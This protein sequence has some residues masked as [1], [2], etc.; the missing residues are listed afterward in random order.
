MIGM[1]V[2][3]ASAPGKILWIGGY[4]VIERPNVSFVTGVNKRVFAKFETLDSQKAIFIIPQFNAKVEA[5]VEGGQIVFESGLSE[6]ERNA[7]KFVRSAAEFSLKYLIAK[8]KQVKGFCLTTVSDPAFAVNGGKSGLGSSAAVT[9]ATVASILN[10]YGFSI[11]SNKD[12]I[13]KIAQLAHSKAQGKVGSGFDVAAATFGGHSYVRYSPSL[14]E[15]IS[16]DANPKEIL[17]LVET[18]WDYII[19][20][21]AMP[22]GFIPVIGNIVGESAST[23]EMVKR[24]NAFKAANSELYRKLMSEIN[25]ANKAAIDALSEI[26]KL[27]ENEQE[28]YKLVLEAVNNSK[29]VE[30]IEE[31]IKIFNDFKL[32]FNAG[33]LLTKKLGELSGVQIES[34]EYSELINETVNNGAFVAKLPGAGGGDSIVAICL[35]RAAK[36]RVESFW[37]SYKKKIEPLDL[38]ISNEG[39]RHETRKTFEEILKL[40]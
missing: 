16:E 39:V 18:T 7:I 6:E 24:V 33:R 14:I 37:R 2:S 28:K 40:V 13:H 17:N 5:K 36:I 8:G 20:P 32:A 9:V 29:K 34:D 27:A 10:A 25:D 35:S 3:F 19:R 1:K 31:E 15:N 30:G 12:N 21:L 4:S 11:E 38:T 26:N 23:S 22:R